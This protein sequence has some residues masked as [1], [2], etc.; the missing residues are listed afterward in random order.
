MKKPLLKSL[1]ML[2]ITCLLWGCYPDGPEYYE[3]YDIVY[4]NYDETHSFGVEGKNYWIPDQILSITD[5]WLSGGDPEFV[6]PFYANLLLN[7]IKANMTDIGY[8]ELSDTTGVDYVLMVSS[9]ETTNI[10]YY[11]DYWYGYYWGW[12]YYY[13][14]PVTY[15]Y[16]TGSL[17]LNLVDTHSTSANGK[18]RVV[19]TGVIN[20]LLEGSSTDFTNRMNKAIDQAFKQSP[21]LQ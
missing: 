20:G 11:Y 6:D 12:G 8:T 4:T 5:E 17:F 16:K 13:P 9:L 14:Y 21:Y 1:L 3:D 7:R 15:S 19:W 10:T 18:K 2:G